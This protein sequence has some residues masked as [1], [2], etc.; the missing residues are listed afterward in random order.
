MLQ[1]CSPNNTRFQQG[2]TL[3]HMLKINVFSVIILLV[4]DGFTS[5]SSHQLLLWFQSQEK[6]ALLQS[7]SYEMG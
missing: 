3:Q 5:I 7:N 4:L 2:L 1:D 6:I